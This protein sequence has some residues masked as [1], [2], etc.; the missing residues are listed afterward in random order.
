[1]SGI[2]AAVA[3]NG[4]NIV[5]LA[6][7][8]GPSGV[9]QSPIN[10]SDANND[11]A[12]TRYWIG[13]YKPASTGSVSF[14]LTTVWSSDDPFNGQYST[15]YVWIGN[16]A[17]SGYNSGNALLSSNNNTGSG[18]ISLVAGQYYPI[19][20]QW[21]AYLPW[22]FSFF[23]NYTTDGS[24]SFSGEGSTNVSGKIFYNRGTNGF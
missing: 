16:V 13:Y 22:N 5:Y 15:G 3:G 23:D 21:S 17:K 8:Y 19:R 2:M 1:M 11:V 7:L 12:F 20:I 10:D 9:D 18:S 4:Q 14:G 24:M 6:G